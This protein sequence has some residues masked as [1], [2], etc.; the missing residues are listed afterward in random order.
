MSAVGESLGP[1]RIAVCVGSGGVGK[2]TV[3][4]AIALR[5]ALQGKKAL[6]CTIDPA[7]RL[8]SALGLA[9]LGNKEAVVPE[10][11]LRQAGLTLPPGGSLHAMM[12]DVKHTWDELIARHAP[13]PERRRRILENR[14]YQQMSRALA[15]SHEYMAM[16][17]LYEL[18]TERDYGLIVL[19]TPPT[20]HALDFLD[21]PH[22]VLDFLGDE[23]LR[24]LGPALAAGRIGMKLLHLG[25]T[26]AARALARFTG[27][28]TLNELA[29]LLQAF[30]GMYDGFKARAAAVRELMGQSQVGF[31][32]VASPQPMSVDEALFFHRTLTE[33]GMTVAG[34]V[35]N[36]ATGPLWPESAPLPEGVE[37]A[38]AAGEGSA[39]LWGRVALTVAEQQR[40]ARAERAEIARLFAVPGTPR[41]ILAR[42]ES[43]VHDLGGLAVVASRV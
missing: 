23:S 37:L 9:A 2:T 7:H 3:A 10:E 5:G 8:A 32:V 40:I 38:R 13:D 36:R 15:G 39:D 12:L 19:D 31:V 24:I 29:A 28:E 43:D 22:R 1:K 21:A 6:V 27:A 33:E 16:E 4:A 18:A 35:V 17:K 25:G 30:E 26:Y 20:A 41:V 14:L 11:M 42:L 34:L